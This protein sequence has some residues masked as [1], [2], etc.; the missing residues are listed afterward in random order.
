MIQKVDNYPFKK[1]VCVSRLLLFLLSAN[2]QIKVNNNHESY[3]LSAPSQADMDEW[4][5]VIK[6]V[7]LSP[8]GGGMWNSVLK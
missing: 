8:F 2:E 7:I 5:K 4:M 6:R 1:K 3:L